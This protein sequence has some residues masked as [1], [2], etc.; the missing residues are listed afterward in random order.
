M[1]QRKT[2]LLAVSYVVEGALFLAVSIWFLWINPLTAGY[3]T[4]PGIMFF[5]YVWLGLMFLSG[6]FYVSRVTGLLR[7]WFRSR[8]PDVIASVLSIPLWSFP[9]LLSL[10]NA[11]TYLTSPYIPAELRPWGFYYLQIGLFFVVIGFF[12]L[13]SLSLSAYLLRT[14]RLQT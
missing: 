2:Q 4:P 1:P 10:G 6:L 8:I 9:A 3:R 14:T 12:N 11:N 5:A 7:G 13:L